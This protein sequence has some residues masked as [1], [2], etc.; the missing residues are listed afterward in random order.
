MLISQIYVDDPAATEQW[1]NTADE[2]LEYT[3]CGGRL[4]D[5]ITQVKVWNRTI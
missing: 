5:V 2:L 3:V 1:Y 4:R